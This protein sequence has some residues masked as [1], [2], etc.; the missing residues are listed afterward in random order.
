MDNIL[1]YEAFVD[2]ELPTPIKGWVKRS[3]LYD[4]DD[5]FVGYEPCTLFA[6][7]SYKDRAP[8]L[9]LLLDEGSLFSF[10]PFDSFFTRVPSDEVRLFSMSELVY[11]NCPDYA[12]ALSS[13]TFLKEPLNCYLYKSDIWLCGEYIAS[14]DWHRDNLIIHLCLLENSQIAALPSHK[15]KFRNGKREFESYRKITKTWEV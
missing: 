2:A 9:K 10:M 15:V 8:T 13:P 3:S 6:I 7:T 11:K 5:S 14:L 12:F 4:D 1:S